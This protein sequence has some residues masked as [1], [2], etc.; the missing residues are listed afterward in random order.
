MRLWNL[1]MRQMSKSDNPENLIILKIL[2]QTTVRGQSTQST[3]N[4]RGVSVPTLWE[5]TC[6]SDLLSALK[7]PP[8]SI[9]GT[10]LTLI[11][12]AMLYPTDNILVDKALVRT[13]MARWTR[14]RISNIARSQKEIQ[15]LM[16]IGI[17]GV[18]AVT[19]KDK[20]ATT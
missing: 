11:G 19:P 8:T 18:L 13:L 20:L 12:C 15:Q 3:P 10:K 5:G 4:T 1:L 16:K 14:L 9:Y 6:P 2:V 7:A 17:E